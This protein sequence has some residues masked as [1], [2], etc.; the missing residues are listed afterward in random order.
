MQRG[1]QVGSGSRESGGGSIHLSLEASV[2]ELEEEY[3]KIIVFSLQCSWS[4]S[5]AGF[6]LPYPQAETYGDSAGGAPASVPWAPGTRSSSSALCP[7]LSG[8]V[9]TFPW[10]QPLCPQ[11]WA[12]TTLPQFPP[13]VASEGEPKGSSLGS[14]W[15]NRRRTRAGSLTSYWACRFRAFWL[16]KPKTLEKCSLRISLNTCKGN[17]TGTNYYTDAYLVP[18]CLIRVT[19]A[20]GECSAILAEVQRKLSWYQ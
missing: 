2:T 6:P 11:M 14:H 3:S 13:T 16:K 10:G 19:T 20:Q 4:I 9:G 18:S 7:C 17:E 8:A 12:N 5:S 1:R 15:G